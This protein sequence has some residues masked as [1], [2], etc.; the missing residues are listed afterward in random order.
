[1]SRKSYHALAL[2]LLLGFAATL[3]PVRA[4]E[5]EA[6]SEDD[7]YEIEDLRAHLVVRKDVKE[8]TVV[9]GNELAVVVTIY[10][11]GTS[12]A[13]DVDVK[14]SFSEESFTLKEG[15]INFHVEKISPGSEESFE[16]VL[17]P[18][19]NGPVSFKQATVT[20]MPGGTSDSKQMATSTAAV[21]LILTSHD[22]VIR[23]I[24]VAG[25]YAT[26]GIFKTARQWQQIGIFL[27]LAVLLIGG[28]WMWS[29][30][31]DARSTH[32]RK[33]ALEELKKE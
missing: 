32:R 33:K 28:N 20:Y 23:S 21:A 13:S 2:L 25:S 27:A 26:L 5:E 4:D 16:Y 19:V 30:L 11:Q 3:T 31:S 15:S 8:D 24:L 1:M 7:D 17:L 22:Y 12:T 18:K 6:D 9:E 14:D 29:S 10:N